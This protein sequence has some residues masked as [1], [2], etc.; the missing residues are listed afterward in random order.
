MLAAEI[1]DPSFRDWHQHYLLHAAQ[2]DDQV[3]LEKLK[4]VR[5]LLTFRCY[6]TQLSDCFWVL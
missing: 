3:L 1:T 6:S 2:Q 5:Y 4:A